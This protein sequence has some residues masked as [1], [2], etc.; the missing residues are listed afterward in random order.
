M[1][2]LVK[3]LFVSF[4]VS[5]ACVE[6][7]EIDFS[8]L[9]PRLVV[10]GEISNIP[11][12]YEVKLFYTTPIDSPLLEP[13]YE[14]GAIITI[15][16][17][18][19]HNEPLYEVLPGIYRTDA[20]GGFKGQVGMTYHVKI[21]TASGEQLAS[22]PHELKEEIP[23]ESIGIEY[24]YDVI[25]EP[26]DTPYEPLDAMKVYAKPLIPI[27]RRDHVRWRFHGTYQATT[28]PE[29]TAM[30]GVRGEL[31]GP[32]VPCSGWFPIGNRIFQLEP[33]TCCVCWANEY[34]E[35]VVLSDDIPGNTQNTGKVLIAT[36]P[37]TGLRFSDRYYIEAQQISLSDELYDFWKL[38][39][40]QQMSGENI[41]QPNSVK[42]RGNIK[43]LTNPDNEILGV[44]SVAGISS[45]VIEIFPADIPTWIPPPDIVPN[46]CRQGLPYGTTQQP[47]YW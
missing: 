25:D 31:I 8:Y 22:T 27:S 33:C 39:K 18:E 44:F 37:I 1:R 41:F 2:S 29:L 47:P 14:T 35:S 36:L 30:W 15:V 9:K 21:T 43:S 38:V 24:E 42:V 19:G 6:S 26:G 12:P 16:D 11:G 20:G 40:A 45:K 4:L 13:K 5:D 32:P 10:E 28:N 34:N 46:D 3:L 17:E 7:L 23:I